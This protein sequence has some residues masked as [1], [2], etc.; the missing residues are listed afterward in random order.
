MVAVQL[1]DKIAYRP[2]GIISEVVQKGG[3][4]VTLFCMSAGSSISEHTASKEAQVLVLEGEGVFVLEGEEVPM[5][6]GTLISFPPEAKHS[7]R[8]D[9]DLSFVLT[10][11]G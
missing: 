10:L 9:T 7:L 3:V 11:L 8:A 6:A 5:R 1:K 4:N 2:G